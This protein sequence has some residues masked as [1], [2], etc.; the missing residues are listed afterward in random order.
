[1]ICYTVVKRNDDN[2]RFYT[3][4]SEFMLFT[5]TKSGKSNMIKSL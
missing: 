1:M 4:Q 5:K 3:S 2:G